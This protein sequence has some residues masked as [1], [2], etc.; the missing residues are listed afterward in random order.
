LDPDEVSSGYRKLAAG[1]RADPGEPELATAIAAAA[2]N[3]RATM[4]RLMCLT[5]YHLFST[6]VAT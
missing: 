5:T 2:A 3:T 4:I 6:L 1:A